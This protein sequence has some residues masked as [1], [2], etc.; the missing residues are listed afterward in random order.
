MQIFRERMLKK[1]DIEQIFIGIETFDNQK[2]Y[3][4]GCYINYL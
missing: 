1:S 4:N 3:N 2:Y